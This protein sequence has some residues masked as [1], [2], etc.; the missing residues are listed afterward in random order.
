MDSGITVTSVFLG[1]LL[2]AFYTISIPL[3]NPMKD[4][5][6]KNK[7]LKLVPECFYSQYHFPD[8]MTSRINFLLYVYMSVNYI[9]ENSSA[10]YN[11]E[12][13]LESNKIEVGYSQR[14]KTCTGSK[15]PL[16]RQ[17]SRT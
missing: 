9:L 17:I 10:T 12:R 6:I 4:P 15:N 1:G 7:I 8:E 11:R 5:G 3:P 2:M 13:F 16:L 14:S